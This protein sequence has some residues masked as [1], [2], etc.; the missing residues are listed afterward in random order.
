[1]SEIVLAESEIS[2]RTCSEDGIEKIEPICLLKHGALRYIG[3]D[4]RRSKRVEDI[5]LRFF[6]EHTLPSGKRMDLFAKNRT[7]RFAWVIEM[8]VHATMA[9]LKQVIEYADEVDEEYFL[10]W[11][12]Y[13][14]RLTQKTILARSFDDDMLYFAEKLGVGLLQYNQITRKHFRIQELSQPYR[15]KKKFAYISEFDHG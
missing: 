12:S 13:R 4:R 5:K 8:K 7:G 1:M 14:F 6:R 3:R 15:L 2:K 10:P 9:A 11:S